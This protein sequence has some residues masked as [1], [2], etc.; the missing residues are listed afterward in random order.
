MYVT[1]HEDG[2]K[3]R[4]RIG[5]SRYFFSFFALPQWY[6]ITID[7][8]YRGRDNTCTPGHDCCTRLHETDRCS[9]SPVRATSVHLGITR[10]LRV[11]ARAREVTCLFPRARAPR[12]THAVDRCNESWS[13][14]DTGVRAT[15]HVARGVVSRSQNGSRRLNIFLLVIALHGDVGSRTVRNPRTAASPRYMCTEVHVYRAS[16]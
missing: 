10:E 12:P 15:W 2:Q 8:L 6:V 14:A 3:N 16:R 7:P 13:V 9:V 1:V 11:R 4:S 5:V